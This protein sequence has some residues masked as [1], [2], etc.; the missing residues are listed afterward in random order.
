VSADLLRRAATRLRESALAATGGSWCSLDGGDRLVSFNLAGQEFGYVV[1][2]PMSNG[3]NAAYI[4]LV[5]PP[6]ALALAAWLD[7]TADRID[8]LSGAYEPDVFDAYIEKA[9]AVP[10]TLARAVLRE[11]TGDAPGEAEHG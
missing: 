8:A 4:A 9:Y 10:N 7:Q 2:E 3:A 11:S 6:V 5:H 1:D